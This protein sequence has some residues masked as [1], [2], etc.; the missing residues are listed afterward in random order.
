MAGGNYDR[1]DDILSGILSQGT[2]LSSVA[3]GA[4]RTISVSN[5]TITGQTAPTNTTVTS[6]SVVVRGASKVTVYMDVTGATT[7]VVISVRAGLSGFGY[8]RVRSITAVAGLQAFTV[9]EHTTGASAEYNGVTR[10]DDMFIEM[11]LSSNTGAGTGVTTTLSTR[12]L[13]QP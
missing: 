11:Q 6:T 9:G 13:T 4:W 5:L 3:N 12:F 7:G 2:D 8:Y 1:T 10:F